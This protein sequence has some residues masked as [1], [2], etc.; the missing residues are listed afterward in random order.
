MRVR[1]HV[2][3][4]DAA[5]ALPLITESATV[6]AVDAMDRN[7]TGEVIDTLQTILTTHGSDQFESVV[8]A[9]AD[10]QRQW[11]RRHLDAI[12]HVEEEGGLEQYLPESLR[13][14]GPG[15]AVKTLQARYL[16]PYPSLVS[17]RVRT[18]EPVEFQPGQYLSVR[19]G[20]VT[21]PYSIASPPTEAELEFC[22]RR[23]PGGALTPELLDAVEPGT[24]LTLR[25]PYGELLLRD[26]STRDVVFLATGTGV[27]PF[28]PMIAHIFESGRD[29]I[30]GVQRDVW[31]FLGAGWADD[32]PYRDYF[33]D[34]DAEYEN[35]QFIPTLS[36]E[37]LLTDWDGETDYVQY[38]LTKYLDPD[39]VT[40][41][42]GHAFQAALASDPVRSLDRR[43]DPMDMD[44]YAC[45]VTAMVNSLVDAVD[46][47]GVPAER[48]EFEAFG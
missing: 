47:L 13:D 6:T 39:K 8:P 17:L 5:E 33:E 7:R 26:P 15:S 9:D 20:S 37:P 21:R 19:F 43:L 1:E 30:D 28:R 35:F 18:E 4:H 16:R 2:S 22:I 32:L 40:T 11:I 25:G 44:V 34:L 27:A 36:R 48:T 24:E 12:D 41:E 14:E 42:L 31:L 38:V 46:R 23:V 10:G 3:Q 29:V 45:G